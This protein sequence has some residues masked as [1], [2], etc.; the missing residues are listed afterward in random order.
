M[1]DIQRRNA[2]AH[3]FNLYPQFLQN[4]LPHVTLYDTVQNE[5][6]PPEANVRFRIPQAFMA[7][8]AVRMIATRFVGSGNA[9][10]AQF[11]RDMSERYRAF[12]RDIV[13]A[14]VEIRCEAKYLDALRVIEGNMA[15][16]IIMALEQEA[17]MDEARMMGAEVDVMNADC[18][19]KAVPFDETDFWLDVFRSF[20]QGWK[21][22]MPQLGTGLEK[23]FLDHAEEFRQAVSDLQH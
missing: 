23:V 17:M 14:G 20:I 6:F 8:F 5:E 15:E 22:G 18:R 9:R 7:Q 21:P 19:S 4:I 2:F 11:G 3:A 12:V 16:T 1:I 10:L 13:G